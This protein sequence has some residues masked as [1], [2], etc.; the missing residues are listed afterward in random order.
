MQATVWL[1]IA[2]KKYG[3]RWAPGTISAT[4]RNKP[5]CRA[6]EIAVKLTLEIPDS[7]FDEPS[8]ELKAILPEAPKKVIEPAEVSKEVAKAISERLGMK[9]KVTMFE[10]G[11]KKPGFSEELKGL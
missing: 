8:F 5:T 6:N 10:P 9:V 1:K 3:S 7:I 2:A 11:E 4:V